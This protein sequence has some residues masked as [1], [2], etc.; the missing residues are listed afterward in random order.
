MTEL[1]SDMSLPNGVPYFMWDEPMTVTEIK[2]RLKNAS[3]SERLR[4]SAKILREARDTDVWEFFSPSE[5]AENWHDI[6][7]KLG[8][9]RKFWEYLL[10]GWKE[11]GLIDF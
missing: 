5:I 9:R 4:L 8:R 11:E 6:A 2:K 3:P 10:S 1:T 7:P